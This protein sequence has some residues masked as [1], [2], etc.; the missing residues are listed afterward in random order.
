MKLSRLSRLAIGLVAVGGLLTVG[1]KLTQDDTAQAVAIPVLADARPIGAQDYAEHMDQ[2]D[3]RIAAAREG[4]DY[5]PG[6]WLPWAAYS[7]ALGR[8]A[9]LAG[10]YADWA[11]ASAAMETSLARSPQG[12]GPVIEAAAQYMALHRL[13]DAEVQLRRVA[14]FAVPALPDEAALV[15][16]LFGDVAFYRGDYDA[17]AAR[18]EKAMANG[19]DAGLLVRGAIHA[20]AMGDLERAEQLLQHAGGLNPHPTRAYVAQINLYLADLEY[21]RGRWDVAKRHVLAARD[22]F[23]GY[24]LAE[25][26]AAQLHALEGD[27]AGAIAGFEKLVGS[28]EHPEFREILATLYREEGRDAEADALVSEAAAIWEQ[29]LATLPHAAMGHAIEHQIKHGDPA[30][31]LELARQDFAWRPYGGTAKMLA[32]ALL[33]ND[34]PAEAEKLLRGMEADGWRATEMYLFLADALEM[35]GKDA[36]A[37]RYRDIAVS[38]DPRALDPLRDYMWFGHS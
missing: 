2:L 26:Y 13:D 38:R 33:M 18:Y 14:G 5:A 1:I 29:R 6:E 22:A 20:R 24:W 8:R 11:E 21:G 9:Q 19:P 10:S 32:E 3:F 34:R 16:A 30:R 25:G 28:Q 31:A 37:K 35:Q 4:R 15:E 7:V 23:P 36:D 17:A 12:A 27:R